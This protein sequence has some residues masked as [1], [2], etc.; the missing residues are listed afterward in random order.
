MCGGN[1]YPIIQK[2]GSIERDAWDCLKWRYYGLIFSHSN[3][4]TSID[5]GGSDDV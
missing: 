1:G 4:K 2:L 3:N 5:T